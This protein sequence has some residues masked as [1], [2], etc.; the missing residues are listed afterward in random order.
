MPKIADGRVFLS[1][2]AYAVVA[3]RPGFITLSA[4]SMS[5]EAFIILFQGKITFIFLC[6]HVLQP[7]LLF[8]NCFLRPVDMVIR[9][10]L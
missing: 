2:S 3:Y 4:V 5:S 6:L 10:S 7:L 8:V 9:E 1:I